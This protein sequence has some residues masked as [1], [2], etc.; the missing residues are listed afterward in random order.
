M[1]I[2]LNIVF[3]CDSY[4]EI[5]VKNMTK[6]KIKENCDINWFNEEIRRIR[7]ENFTN[8]VQQKQ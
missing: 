3:V 4:L 7:R 5:A 2:G 1:N 6:R 8:I